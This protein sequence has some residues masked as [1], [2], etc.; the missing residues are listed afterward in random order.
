MKKYVSI[1]TFLC[2]MGN[3]SPIMALNETNIASVAATRQAQKTVTG[4]VYDKAG[5]PV[6]G[7]NVVLRSNSTQ[8]TITDIDGKFS[9]ANV[10][11][12]AVLVVSF[13]GY[14]NKEV[15]IVP[16]KNSY[17]IV[18]EED[19]E[20]LDEVIV[21]GYGTQKKVNLTGAVAA[22]DEG[23][24]ESRSAPSVAHMLQGVVPGLNIN[25]S[26]GRPGNSAAV[27]IRGIASITD[28]NASPLILI[29]G[30]E[31]DLMK[32]NANDVASISVIKDASASAIYGARAA[33]GVILVTTKTGDGSGKVTVNYNGRFGWNTPTTRTDWESRGYYS[34]YINNLFW[35]A[36][37]GTTNYVNYTDEEMQML[38]D[39]R[40]DKT[41]H[42]DRPWV[43]RETVNGK[44]VYSMYGN[45]DW[46]HYL[47]KD[48][49]PNMS[50]NISLSG[51]NNQIKFLLSGNY[52]SEDGMIRHGKDQ[53]QRYNF[54][55]KIDFKVNDW[56]KISNNTS[57]YNYKYQY[58]GR[59]GV[60]QVFSLMTVHALASY[61]P[62]LPDGGALYTTRY[63]GYTV[64]DGMVTMFET[65]G[66][67]NEDR[68]DNM[69]TT[70]EVA[71]T[72]IKGL[73]IK[74]NF[75]YMFH[76]SRTM[77]R[78]VNTTYS[79]APDV[80]ETLSTLGTTKDKLYETLTNHKYYQA[81]L[82]ATYEHTLAQKHNFKAMAGFNYETKYL[83][84]VKATAYNTF[85]DNLND[86]NLI[87][88]N[89]DGEKEVDLSG[90]QNE[91]AL[92]GYFGRINYDYKGKY[93][94]EASGRYDG[95]SRFRRGERWGFFPSASVG[96]RASE[97]NFFQPIK[98]WF[99]NLKFRFSYGELGNQNVGY[100]DY[101]RK[102]SVGTQSFYFGGDKSTVATIGSPVASNLTWETS[103]HYNWGIDASFLN[104]RLSLSADY[105]I[106]DT[107]DMLTEGVALP[108]VYGASAPKTNT[109]DLRTKGYEL[110]L[111]W[112]DH[113][114]LANKPFNYGL[115]LTFNDNVTDITKYANPEMTFA[116]SYYEGM[117][118]GEI[119]GYR[120]GGLFKSDEEAAA[121]EVD[122][123]YVCSRIY[124]RNGSERGL[125]GGDLKYLDL[126]GNNKIDNGQNTVLD[127]GDMEII[128]NTQPRY[129]YGATGNFSWNG[130][131][132]S[133]FFQGVGKQDWYPATNNQLFWGPYNRP[134]ATLIPKDFHEM[135]WTEE[136]TDA[137]FPR[138]RGY[139]AQSSRRELA[140]VN[141]RYLQDLSYLRL[142][143]LTIGYTLPQQWTRKA[144]I[145]KLRVYFSGENLHYWAPGFHSEYI[146][147]E[148]AA[149]AATGLGN[150]QL[151][152]YS[153]SKTFSFGIDITF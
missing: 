128:G 136:N 120:T 33:Y 8:G 40:N 59:S 82:F 67:K 113:F 87:G 50:H 109:A 85:S 42:P 11:N 73:E 117:R 141:D 14:Q 96:W 84:D 152:D 132:F 30:V 15:K 47:F 137:Y 35:K 115:T 21:V 121:Y 5:Q 26:S 43:I 77:N 38:W 18:L 88:T 148:Q 93:L 111:S 99:S 23:K 89:A 28:S 139:V 61:V 144:M 70:T 94:L 66:H 62:V 55:S 122:Q 36:D 91:Y 116:K 153:W 48:S 145:E 114:E 54:R 10:S 3:I 72:P 37:A 9:I 1:L 107:K 112:R 92:M 151:R 104:D 16:N 127:P 100:Y 125:R 106:R 20:T 71:Y 149:A 80:I 58:P 119:W 126:N 79:A 39:R 143:N 68:Q 17:Q 123:S 95:T 102:I 51:G 2:C 34:V 138:P 90:G 60:A 129:I 134:Y 19:N 24:L 29:D 64:M 146:D 69:S 63:N 45:T 41:E 98:D 142:K 6:I 27:N 25:A 53:L 76:N 105:Y 46:Y 103:I 150:N 12:G 131:D 57:Y 110:M 86:F 31:G 32:I 4:V 81:N 130:L 78:Q 108:A 49:R 97:E 118:W 140:T 83:K 65:G 124:S 56:I 74:G 13:I 133:I 44:E 135:Y 75:T 52:Y 22:I 147:P 7:A 101:I